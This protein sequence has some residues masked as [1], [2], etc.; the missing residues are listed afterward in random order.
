MGWIDDVQ[1]VCERV[2]IPCSVQQGRILPLLP[3]LIAHTI[4]GRIAHRTR[5]RRPQRL[6]EGAHG[7]QGNRLIQGVA[8]LLSPTQ[9]VG[10]PIRPVVKLDVSQVQATRETGYR[11]GVLSRTEGGNEAVAQSVRGRGAHLHGAGRAGRGLGN[12]VTADRQ[13]SKIDEAGA[14]ARDLTNR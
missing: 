11:L 2:R 5:A 3:L 14:L 13:L 10:V 7:R 4:D 1:E 9:Q 6:D 12:A 8:V